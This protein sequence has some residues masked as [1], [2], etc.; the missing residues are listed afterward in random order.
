MRADSV[1]GGSQDMEALREYMAQ[2]R[3][4]AGFILIGVFLGLASLSPWPP[5]G[6]AAASSLT[7]LAVFR[8]VAL[9]A[10]FSLL[11]T[12]LV[13]LLFGKL[14]SDSSVIARLAYE[15]LVIR[16]PRSI[17]AMVAPCF[18]AMAGVGT[19]VAFTG[20]GHSVSRMIP[21]LCLLFVTGAIP[22]LAVCLLTDFQSPTTA[23]WLRSGRVV[24]LL[25]LLISA[26][27]LVCLRFDACFRGTC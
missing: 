21:F 26:G 9:L 3:E 23:R 5:L 13:G 27:L 16:P 20:D 2:Y 1:G 12:S 4:S 17:T 8:V 11:V 18:W 15:G 6:E 14:R 10:I 19:V 24:G 25:L 7:E 22:A